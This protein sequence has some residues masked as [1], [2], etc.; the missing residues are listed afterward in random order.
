MM[1]AGRGLA[2]AHAEGVVHRD[3]K[4]ENI[5][6]GTSGRVCVSDFGLSRLAA[7]MESTE[8][9]ERGG[10]RDAGPT[11]STIAG[12]TPR[13]MA[14]EQ[15]EGATATA[16]SDQFSFSIA[17]YEAL[18]GEHP[19]GR[20]GRGGAASWQV[21]LGP[22][23]SDVPG[24]V[25]RSL[26]RGLSKDPGDRYATIEDL[27]AELGKDPSIKRRRVVTTLGA[28]AVLATAGGA[29][30]HARQVRRDVCA[31][32]DARLHGVWDEGR[33]KAGAQAFEAVGT[34][35]AK[36]EWG[37]VERAL[38]RYTGQW[39]RA[40][41]Q[42]CE[43]VLATGEPADVERNSQVMCL[44][45]RLEETEAV[46]S[47]VVSVTSDDQVGSAVTAA[48]S[49]QTI[50]SCARASEPLHAGR[51]TPEKLARAAGIRADLARATALSYFGRS[52]EALALADKAVEAAEHEG[53]DALL[54]R[55]LRRA[56]HAHTNLGRAD[57]KAEEARLYRAIELADGVGDDE[58][59]ASAWH[60]L[61]F[62]TGVVE[63]TATLVEARRFFEQGMSAVRRLGGDDV[64]EGLLR[65]AFASVLSLQG[66]DEESQGQF[67][68]ALTASTRAG[69][70]L[71][72]GEILD[73]LG[74]ADLAGGNLQAASEHFRRAEETLVP[75]VGERHRFVLT[76][77]NDEALLHLQRGDFAAARDVAKT[78]AD[79]FAALGR[80]ESDDASVALAT[81]A[82]AL[83]ELHD[84]ERARLMAAR[85]VEVRDKLKVPPTRLVGPLATLG[86][87]WVELHE[88]ASA[89]A[90][91]ER[92]VSS[93][94]GDPESRAD[95]RFALAR[96]LTE[97]HRDAERATAL[98]S[99]AKGLLDKLPNP[100]P[101]QIRKR[102][103]VRAFLAGPARP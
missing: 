14:P 3:L 59:R 79:G 55:A 23:K 84:A 39:V 43:A 21:Q 9:I 2:A 78:V 33:K 1:L 11:V 12:G 58:T 98:A 41:T 92:A 74:Q 17:M 7:G 30:A 37:F 95:A 70:R 73:N 42:A 94:K 102:E 32:A 24:W 53:D 103:Q 82:D 46:V 20:T 80:G 34:P 47:G 101:L 90:P 28:I 72:V 97:L 25:R 63:R 4:P 31:H 71:L 61:L 56:A 93:D 50:A 68:L 18:Y 87:A 49:I 64:Q 40:R 19:F 6:V 89:L 35:F 38:D 60:E 62:I 66:E 85:S 29:A 81:L 67:E 22:P 45:D 48:E 57:W 76:V 65:N 83:M 16:R 8:R 77:R 99:E 69:Y 15:H 91:L 52:E 51:A 5:L 10:S 44:D 26:L 13:Y 96:A 54:A 36:D 86:R 75:L 88:P 100:T 27:L